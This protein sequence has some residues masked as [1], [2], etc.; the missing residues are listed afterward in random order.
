V[1]IALTI[2][3]KKLK[4]SVSIVVLPPIVM[5]DATMIIAKVRKREACGGE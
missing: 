1:R 2:R 5:D 3:K 4:A